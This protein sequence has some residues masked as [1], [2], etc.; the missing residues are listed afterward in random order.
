MWWLKDAADANV[1][2]VTEAWK[3]EAAHDASLL[4]PAVQ[5]AIPRAKLIV[6]GFEKVAMT[7]PV[8]GGNGP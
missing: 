1:A 7:R 8:W 5:A 2:W 4:L 3:S 6:T